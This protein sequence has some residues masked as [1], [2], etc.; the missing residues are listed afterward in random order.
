MIFHTFVLMNLFNQINSRKLGWR[1][2]NIFERFFN[3]FKFLLV[4]ALEFA[5]Q[6][7][8][9]IYGGSIF[10]TS[11]L[12][13]DQ[14]ITCFFFGFGSLLVGMGMKFIPLSE[15]GRFLYD[16]NESGV[17]SEDGVLARFASKKDEKREKLLD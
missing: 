8:I 6:Y 10:R 7:L 2:F 11:P 12:A 9:V 3:N 4:L 13:W 5:V 14:H 1:D 16:F 15:E 17:L